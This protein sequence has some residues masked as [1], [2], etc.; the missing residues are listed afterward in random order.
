MNFGR[1]LFLSLLGTSFYLSCALSFSIPTPNLKT[2]KG[3]S[4]LVSSRSNFLKGAA[5]TLS[6]IGFAPPFVSAADDQKKLRNISDEELK[7][8]IT[9]DIV[10]KSFLASADLTREVYDESAIFTDEIDSY[11]LPKWIK[12]TKQLF[13]AEKSRV[14]LVG[15]VNVSKEQVDF[16]FDEDLMFRIPFTPVVYLSGKVVLKRD[17]GSGLITSYQEIW[18]QDVKTVLKSAKFN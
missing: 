16:R 17:P 1:S 10:E 11:T 2:S 13:V 8:I 12:G 18:D 6:V 5:A 14:S 15:D 7:R 3:N 4:N 9:A